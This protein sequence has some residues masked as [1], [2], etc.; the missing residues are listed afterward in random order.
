[1]LERFGFLQ[2]RLHQLLFRLTA[3]S[4]LR[5]GRSALPRAGPGTRMGWKPVLLAVPQAV[6]SFASLMGTSYL[7]PA[8]MK[9]QLANIVLDNRSEF[10]FTLISRRSFFFFYIRFLFYGGF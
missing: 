6:K 7:L 2:F 1:M 8:P 4:E 3:W 10:I 9:W 5:P